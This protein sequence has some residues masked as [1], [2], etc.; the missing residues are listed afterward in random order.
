MQW[1]G[2]AVDVTW[3]DEEPPQDIYSQALRAALKSGGIVY[4]TFTPESGMTDVVTQFMTKLGQSQALYHA[5]WDDAKHLNEDVKKEILA[6]LPPHERDMR[7]KGVPILG[8]GLVFPVSEED[9]E[10]EP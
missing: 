8:S 9:L 5:T 1:M 10:V 3:L 6:A 2:K 7:S 4:M